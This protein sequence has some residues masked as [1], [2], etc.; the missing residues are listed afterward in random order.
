MSIDNIKPSEWDAAY[1]K[2]ALSEDTV[3]DPVD[4]PEHYNTGNIEC[5]DAMRA[6]SRNAELEPFQGYLWLNA[7]KYLWRW[8]YKSKPIEDLRKARW[9]IDRLIREYNNGNN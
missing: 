6:A 1:V 4:R 5:I 9:Y 8:P 3:H 7:F 2:F